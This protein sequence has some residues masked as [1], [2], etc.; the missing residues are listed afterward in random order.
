MVRYP[1][2]MF[3]LVLG[4]IAGHLNYWMWDDAR[5]VLVLSINRTATPNKNMCL[6]FNLSSLFHRIGLS[7]ESDLRDRFLVDCSFRVP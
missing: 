1:K 7:R 4:R 6:D 5:L 3:G 2:W